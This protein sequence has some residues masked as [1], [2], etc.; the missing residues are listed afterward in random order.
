MI[1]I[2]PSAY[3]PMR[4]KCSQRWSRAI[5]SSSDIAGML[6]VAVI[7]GLLRLWSCGYDG[8]RGLGNYG[9]RRFT[10]APLDDDVGEHEG[11]RAQEDHRADHV[12]LGWDGHARGAPDEQRERG[13]RTRVE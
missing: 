1:G 7:G 2:P 6:P 13:L 9:E 5:C 8:R 4:V 3:A 12:D 11:D 10:T